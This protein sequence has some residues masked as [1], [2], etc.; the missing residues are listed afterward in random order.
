MGITVVKAATT[1]IQG[2]LKREVVRKFS[3][4]MTKENKE[5]NNCYNSFDKLLKI[6]MGDTMK[7]FLI[8][9]ATILLGVFVFVQTAPAADTTFHG[10]FRINSWYQSMDPDTG[11]SVSSQASRLRYRPTW[12]VSFDNGVKLQQYFWGYLFSCRRPP[13]LTPHSTAS[14]G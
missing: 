4:R 7:K 2:K 11:D 3:R 12:D 6:F 1:R 9:A 14:S 8:V 10:Q 13:R 5:P